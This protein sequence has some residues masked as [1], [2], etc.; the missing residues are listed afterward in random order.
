MS[1]V[2]REQARDMSDAHAQGLHTDNPR[3][4]CPECTGRSLDS[5]P[6]AKS[7]ATATPRTIAQ[8]IT[9]ALRAHSPGTKD[10]YLSASS[11]E[12]AELY[13]HLANGQRFYVTVRDDSDYD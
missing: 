3:E 4:F 9:D 5:Y 12:W 6:P 11:D 2:T 10:A 13:V 7:A 8:A 1:E